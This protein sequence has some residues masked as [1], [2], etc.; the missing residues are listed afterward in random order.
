MGRAQ[1]G[2]SQMSP[3]KPSTMPPTNPDAFRRLVEGQITPAE[4]VR[5]LDE[6]IQ[7]T[8]AAEAEKELLAGR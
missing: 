3:P 4:Y 2:I 7:R 5:N 6:R 8:R 1:G